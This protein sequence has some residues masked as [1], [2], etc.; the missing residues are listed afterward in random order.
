MYECVW[1]LMHL[2]IYQRLLHYSVKFSGRLSYYW[3]S[4]L[5]TILRWYSSYVYNGSSLHFLFLSLSLT[6]T[7]SLSLSAS[8]PLTFLRQQV[9][10][11]IHLCW[12][13][14]Q[15]LCVH[16]CVCILVFICFCVHI[17]IWRIYIS[18][19]V[20]YCFVLIEKNSSDI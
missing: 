16:A 15:N 7:L 11:L 13:R 2:C 6:H 1:I 9:N 18:K 17:C 20:Y 4:V 8:L 12:R 14:Y 19:Y 10:W 5:L 3:L